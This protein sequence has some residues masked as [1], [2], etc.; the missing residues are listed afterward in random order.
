MCEME[1]DV[2]LFTRGNGK[3]KCQP[4]Q[5]CPTNLGDSERYVVKVRPPYRNGGRY[6]RSRL[7]F[8]LSAK[9][10]KGKK[11][12]TQGKNSKLKQKTHEFGTI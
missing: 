11:L 1:N 12:K 3:V 2:S 9:K 10:L 8:W 4:D 6:G 7:D 5:D